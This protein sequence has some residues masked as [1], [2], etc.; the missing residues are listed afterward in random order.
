V[1]RVHIPFLDAK[2]WVVKRDV[3]GIQ[4]EIRGIGVRRFDAELQFQGIPIENVDAALILAS[5]Y[6]PS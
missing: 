2:I 5:R 1:R 4:A 3:L 6:L